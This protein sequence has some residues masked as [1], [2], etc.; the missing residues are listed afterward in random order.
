MLEA[1][2][3]FRLRNGIYIEVTAYD[4][5]GKLALGITVPP[6]GD[7]ALNLEAA[8]IER[9]AISEM[10]W[11]ALEDRRVIILMERKRDGAF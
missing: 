3:R 2:F 5:N 4:N 1:E 7:Y 9:S 6:V 10:A 8:Y 11:E